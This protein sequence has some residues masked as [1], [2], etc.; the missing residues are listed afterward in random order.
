MS[1][2][3]KNLFGRLLSAAVVS[4]ALSSAFGQA[5]L[6]GRRLIWSDEFNA[7]GSPDP[8]KWNY[9]VG[10]VRNREAQYYTSNRVENVRQ[11]NGCLVIE[12][13]KEKFNG[14][15]YTSGSLTTFGKFSFKYGRAEMRAKLPG[16]RGTW[17][18][19]WMMGVTRPTIGWPICGEID[20][21]E[22]VGYDPEVIHSAIHFGGEPEKGSKRHPHKSMGGKLAGKK[23]AGEFH[24]YA[25]EWTPEKLEFFFDDERIASIDLDKTKTKKYNPFRQPHS[26]LINLAI[27]GSWGG[28]QGIDDAIFPCRY[29]IDYIRVYSERR[30]QERIP[31]LGY[32]LDVSRSKVPTM[33]TLFRMVDVLS[34]LGYNELQLYTEHTFRYS[35][36]EVAW[37]EASPMT[38][39]EVRR[40]DDYCAKKGISLVANQNSFGHLENWLV[41]PEYN[42]LAECPTAGTSYKRW[43]YISTRPMCLCPTDPRSIEF[44]DGL[45]EELLPCF[46]SNFVNVGCDETIELLDDG[47]PRVGRSAAAIREKGAHRVYLEFLLKIHALLE[48]RG[49]RMMFWGD[50]MLHEPELFD[51]LPKDVVCLN[52]GYEDD[53][54]FERETAVLEKAGIDFYVC[55]GTSSWC[56]LVGRFSNMIKNIDLAVESGERNGAKGLLLTDWGDTGHPHPWIVSMPA[57]VYTAMRVRGEK[58]SRE[59][60]AA[61]IDRVVGAKCGAALIKMGDAYLKAGGST[62]NVSV[63]DTILRRDP[64]KKWPNGVTKE[65]MEAALAQ[66]RDAENDVDLNGAPEWVSDGFAMVKLLREALECRVRKPKMRNFRAMFETR[67]RTLWLKYNRTGGLT[68]SLNRVFGL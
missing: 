55:P 39:E 60:L 38:P 21:F 57:I 61:E 9:E 58:P 26:M 48:K 59:S 67:Y 27:G 6:E 41:H 51:S 44:V 63:L 46:R 34:S 5:N 53:H 31:T 29:E 49:K 47:D 12:A 1:H 2:S 56:A 66:W 65:T 28:K 64:E 36:H 35:K 54:P 42:V 68:R 7:T 10:F 11:E 22:H 62:R 37:R 14:A 45:F 19:F 17:P 23:I 16:G 8:A 13:R 50:I 4:M 30:K 20:V 52:W 43:G 18:A 3:K 40:L 33:P 24:I 25:V 32:M 15:E